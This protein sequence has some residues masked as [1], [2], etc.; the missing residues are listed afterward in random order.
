M[1]SQLLSSKPKT[2]LI[3]LLLAHPG[4]SFS[5]TELRINSGCPSPLLKQTIK[6]LLKMDFLIIIEKKRIKYYEMNKH[7]PLYPELVNLLRKIKNIPGDELA[8]QATKIGECKL[9]A[10][11]GLFVGR[12]R[13]E[14]DL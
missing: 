12:P 4:R 14:S 10:L 5:Y 1:L 2:N 13:I 8:K 6:D 7:F 3:N 9:V 11:T